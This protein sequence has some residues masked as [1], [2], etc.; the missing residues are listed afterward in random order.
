MIGCLYRYW[1][2]GTWAALA[3]AIRGTNLVL[4]PALALA[5]WLRPTRPVDYVRVFAPPV[6]AV[7]LITAYNFF[8]FQSF[9]EG[10]PSNPLKDGFVEGLLGILL[11]PGLGLLIS[12]PIAIFALS[13]LRQRA[14]T[15]REN[16]CLAVLAAGV[17]SLLHIA[18]MAIW[19][20][21]PATL[22]SEL[23]KEAS[24]GNHTRLSKRNGP[25]DRRKLC[26]PPGA[27]PTGKELGL[28]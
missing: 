24:T 2:M 16:H 17:F 10:Y 4:L 12:T 28:L 3:L 27:V 8:V 20:F 26:D 7:A 9:A 18:V 19:R 5:L 1:I 25:A 22:Q 14:R 15:S 11:S 23:P 6:L 21:G 13:A